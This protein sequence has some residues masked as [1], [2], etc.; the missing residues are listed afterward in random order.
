MSWWLRRPGASGKV[1]VAT[2]LLGAL[3][4]TG[5]VAVAPAYAATPRQQEWYINAMSMPDIWK[6][7][8]GRGVTVAVIDGQV[9]ASLPDLRGQVLP[10][11]NFSPEVKPDLLSSD[12][13]HG[14]A[15]SSIIAG[16]GRGEG[17]DGTIGIAPKAK[18]LPLR[19][20][21]NLAATDEGAAEAVYIPQLARAI[22]YA[23]DSPARIINMSV[24]ASYAT[25]GLK[26]AVAYALSKGKLLFAAVGNSRQSDN[27]VQYPAGIPGV[28]GVAALDKKGNATSESET[29]PQVALSAPG[30]DMVHACQGGAG[31]CESHGT[32]DATAIVSGAAAL[33][34]AKHPSWTNWQ[35]LRAL[36][37]TAA[38][39]LNGA[40]R[41]DFIGYGLV[42]PR[43]A[44]EYKGDS[45]S[46]D[47][48]P[49]L[50]GTAKSASPTAPATAST[51]SSALAGTAPA[52]ASSS[53][54]VGSLPWTAGGAVVAVL[55]VGGF[56]AVRRR[57]R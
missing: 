6:I 9:D 18:I 5:S 10:Q 15:M 48:D 17:G 36:I 42:R 4:L 41:N 28:V 56:V 13:V 22:R 29:G 52:A 40:K 44:M 49:L 34:W 23:A 19:V 45:G 53:G 26:S 7:S 11:R 39:P 25:P 47:V 57:A 46:A 50:P 43:R 20:V 24:G 1:L 30:M 14:T 16:S 32:S 8:E 3:G 38:G 37:N 54:G 55:L 51:P 27:A 35:V 12:S 33:V 31:I 21:V 2:A